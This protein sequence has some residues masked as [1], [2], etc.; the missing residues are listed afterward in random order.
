MK[1]PEA[2]IERR[3]GAWSTLHQDLVCNASPPEHYAGN[4]PD[5]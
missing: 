5:A 2:R 1:S 3:V 4:Q